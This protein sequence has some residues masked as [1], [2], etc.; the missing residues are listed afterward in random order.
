MP[1][2]FRLGLWSSRSAALVIGVSGSLLDTQS[3]LEQVR[4]S[5]SP[6]RLIDPRLSRY[7]LHTLPEASSPP[8][9]PGQS[10]LL[11]APPSDQTSKG[12]SLPPGREHRRT[13][14][15]HNTQ[16]QCPGRF[17]IASLLSPG[18]QSPCQTGKSRAECPQAPCSS[19]VL[20][21]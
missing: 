4:R 3:F 7:P 10:P 5:S 13:T 2:P 11:T 15:L 12:R 6:S 18:P 17:W 8:V 16:R 21:T 9:K 14:G 19:R 1:S 20:K